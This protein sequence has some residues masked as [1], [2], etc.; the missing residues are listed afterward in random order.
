MPRVGLAIGV[1]A[2]GLACGFG[3]RAG[4]VNLQGAQPLR[5]PTCR[6]IGAGR[7]RF[8][9]ACALD[10]ARIRIAVQARGSRTAHLSTCSGM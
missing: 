1:T 10:H 9:I 5:N 7:E 6:L 3:A 8:K 4:L 2:R